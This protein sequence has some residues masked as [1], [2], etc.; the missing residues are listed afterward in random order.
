M[1]TFFGFCA[2][3]FLG[4]LTALA[5]GKSS[6]VAQSAPNA[7]L[8][9]VLKKLDET[10]AHFR[11]AQANFEW[12]RYEKVINEVDDIQT[13]VIYYRRVG[14]EVEMKADVKKEGDDPGKLSPQEKVVLF[15]NSKVQLYQPRANQLTIYNAGKNRD[16]LESYFVLGFGGSGQE[17]MNS[18]DVSYQGQESINAVQT[19]KLQLI[20]KSAKV[21]NNISEITLWIDLQRGVSVQQKFSEPQGDYRLAKYSDIKINEKINPDIFQI[22]T[23]PNTQIISR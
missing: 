5:G 2:I 6:V 14:K 8:E 11:T 16:E 20:P 18:F 9:P 19:A 12:D 7:Q 15:S 13:G 23:K 10:A 17:M 21:K 4:V 3:A 22:R 1:K